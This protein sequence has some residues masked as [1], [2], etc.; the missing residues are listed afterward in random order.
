M[1]FSFDEEVSPKEYLIFTTSRRFQGDSL[2]KL[3]PVSQRPFC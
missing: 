2:F 1:T 3:G